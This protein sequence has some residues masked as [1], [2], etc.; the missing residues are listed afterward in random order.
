MG[1]PLH[2]TLRQR[3]RAGGGNILTSPMG[4]SSDTQM[5]SD[6]RGPSRGP[7]AGTQLGCPPAGT[8]PR[9]MAPREGQSPVPLGG[10][11]RRVLEP[12]CPPPALQAALAIPAAWTRAW[13][14]PPLLPPR[15]RCGR[16][17]PAPGA[18]RPPTQPA[19][20]ARRS[21]HLSQP[22][23]NVP[24]GRLPPGEK[25]RLL[26]SIPRKSGLGW[27]LPGRTSCVCSPLITG[28]VCGQTGGRGR[29]AG[30]VP[31]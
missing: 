24:A 20:P 18:R 26:C 12:T 5:W 15:A 10:E 29:G 22:A 31:G 28:Y 4:F 1:H 6:G 27:A 2:G 16:R 30:G 7:S 8:G 17:W 14:W 25:G 9:G 13:P 3:T 23:G 21:L 19:R 11:A